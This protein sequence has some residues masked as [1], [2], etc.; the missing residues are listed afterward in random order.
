MSMNLRKVVRHPGVSGDGKV[1]VAPHEVQRDVRG[2]S[3]ATALC[4]ERI[5]PPTWIDLKRVDCAAC[6]TELE[7]LKMAKVTTHAVVTGWA[8]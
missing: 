6:R 8:A 7:K 4:G 3:Y 1:H 2:Y 5:K